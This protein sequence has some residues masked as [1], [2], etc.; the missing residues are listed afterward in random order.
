MARKLLVIPVFHTEAE[1]GSVR[2]FM[3]RV[4]ERA[5]GRGA[6]EEHR[7]E[8]ERFWVDL[9]NSLK[10]KLEGMDLGRVKLYQDGQVINGPLGIKMVEEIARRGSKNHQILLGLIRGGA[11]LMRTENFEL[12][13]E[14]YKFIRAIAAARNPAEA[15]MATRAYRSR[16]GSLLRDRDNYIAKNIDR[17]L[18]EGELGILFVGAT[19][20]VEEN[21]PEGIEVEYLDEIMPVA[22]KIAEKLERMTR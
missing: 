2:G 11:T 12:L 22:S 8:L 19:H 4:S 15:E 17:S 7:R 21:L 20:R 10:Q 1:M 5:F 6:W 14:E 18:E 9:E 3:E 16:K 13:K